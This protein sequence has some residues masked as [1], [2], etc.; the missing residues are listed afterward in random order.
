MRFLD[1]ETVHVQQTI[2]TN[3]RCTRT[4]ITARFHV[5]FI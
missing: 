1:V 4:T 2:I 5:H 3:R